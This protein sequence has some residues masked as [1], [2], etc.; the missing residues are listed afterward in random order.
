M[1]TPN[2]G[3]EDRPND[4]NPDEVR[5]S[6]PGKTYQAQ[7]KINIVQSGLGREQ[8]QMPADEHIEH[9][10]SQIGSDEQDS[11]HP[12]YMND[13]TSADR[14]TGNGEDNWDGNSSRSARHK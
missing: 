3:R 12:G 10:F 14:D 13:A 11:H 7:H 4:I 1:E 5:H 6:E 9:R 2:Q 8:G